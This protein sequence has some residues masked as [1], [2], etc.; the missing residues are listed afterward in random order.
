MALPKFPSISAPSYGLE[1]TVHKAQVR[2]EFGAGYVQ[3]RPKFTRAR[4][5]WPLHWDAL[6][7]IEYQQLKAFFIANQ[8]GAFEWTHPLSG[9]VYVCVFSADE[10][11]GGMDFPGHRVVDCPIEEQ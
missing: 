3:T 5:R 11:T 1:E 9:V 6:P 8:G 4:H 10:M 7:E 2:N